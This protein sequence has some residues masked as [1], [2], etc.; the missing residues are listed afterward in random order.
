MKLV[1]VRDQGHELLSCPGFWRG[2]GKFMF[3]EELLSACLPRPPGLCVV[4]LEPA[5]LRLGGRLQ[6]LLHFLGEDLGRSFLNKRTQKQNPTLPWALGDS[7]SLKDD[8]P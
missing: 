6:G 1:L 8:D 5:L 4:L 7:S 3:F 2:L